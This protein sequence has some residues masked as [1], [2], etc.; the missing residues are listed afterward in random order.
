MAAGNVFAPV[1]PPNMDSIIRKR[2]LKSGLLCWCGP[3]S[4]CFMISALCSVLW[5]CFGPALFWLTVC[6]KHVLGGREWSDCRG[7]DVF[8]KDKDAGLPFS[9]LFLSFFPRWCSAH[10]IAP[11]PE[12]FSSEI[13]LIYWLGT[14]GRMLEDCWKTVWAKVLLVPDQDA[15]SEAAARHVSGWSCSG[16]LLPED[17]ASSSKWD[18]C[19]FGC[20]KWPQQ[21]GSFQCCLKSI[22]LWWNVRCVQCLRVNG[23]G[24]W[25]GGGVWVWTP[26]TLQLLG[27]MWEQIA[28]PVGGWGSA[29]RRWWWRM[30]SGRVGAQPSVPSPF[31]LL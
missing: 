16:E 17:S 21:R 26:H 27:S 1:K 11:K 23:G 29:R 3:T 19:T 8:K 13:G 14:S 28:P 5:R 7:A 22:F 4:A 6:C 24:G 15:G 10:L 25:G 2:R 9:R 30:R 12:V 31:H 20:L 18:K